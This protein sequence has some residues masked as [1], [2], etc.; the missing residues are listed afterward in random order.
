LSIKTKSLFKQINLLNILLAAGIIVLA[1]YTVSPFT[2]A[3]IKLRLPLQKKQVVAEQQK[4]AERSLPSLSDYIAI[5]EE[6]LFNPERKIPAPE[7]NPD[8]KPLPKPE[9]VLYGTL[10]A[11]DTKLAY[12]E[13]LN[14][15]RSTPG[16]GERQVV[17][18]KGDTLSGFTLEE[19]DID[20]VVM[21]RG[22]EKMT[23]HVLEPGKPKARGQA[24]QAPQQVHPPASREIGRPS[25]AVPRQPR[26]SV[27]PFGP[28][29]SRP[30][31]GVALTPA[32]E[33]AR[34]FF[35]SR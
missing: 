21:V 23:I 20:K 35:R 11:D 1:L 32:E 12:L 14:D 18:K 26:P 6:N 29:P 25:A 4:P 2:N 10:I 30:K 33:R 31:N 8:E 16:R 5:A 34:R 7:N 17:V 15:P 24:G 13:D 9:F 27:R 3:N 28:P 22:D 19:V